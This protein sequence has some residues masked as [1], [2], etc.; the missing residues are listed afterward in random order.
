MNID[1]GDHV[2]VDGAAWFTV[3]PYE[4][5]IFLK[6]DGTL[7]VAVYEEDEENILSAPLHEAEITP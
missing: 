1:D 7:R 6:Q 3:G 2:L 5:R 4:V